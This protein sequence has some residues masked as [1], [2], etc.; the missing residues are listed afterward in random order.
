MPAVTREDEHLL[1]DLHSTRFK[2]IG[3]D[4]PVQMRLQRSRLPLPT[5]F[6]E[7]S[8]RSSL[9]SSVHVLA[10]NRYSD[11]KILS[12]NYY[13]QT[14]RGQTHLSSSSSH[15]DSGV[16]SPAQSGVERRQPGRGRERLRT[17]ENVDEEQMKLLIIKSRKRETCV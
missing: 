11:D 16:Y 5:P 4:L 8:R 12:P 10:T 7:A 15:R 2:G 17:M 9:L 3:E 13:C 14:R 6:D 1:R